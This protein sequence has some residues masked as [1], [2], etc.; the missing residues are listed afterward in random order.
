MAKVNFLTAVLLQQ[1][2]DGLQVDRNEA[3]VVEPQVIFSACFGKAFLLLH[4]AIM[5]NFLE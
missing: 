3:D 4:P 2:P 5:Q 1:I